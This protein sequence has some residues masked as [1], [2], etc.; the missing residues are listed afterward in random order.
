VKVFPPNPAVRTG[1]VVVAVA[2]VVAAAT[3]AVRAGSV[4]A[5]SISACVADPT[6]AVTIVSDPTGY[7]SG[8]ACKDAGFHALSWD[9]AGPQGPKGAQGPQ[10]P[11]G[12]AG[13]L[14]VS[15][16]ATVEKDLAL[17]QS[18]LKRLA[19]AIAAIPAQQAQQRKAF[20]RLR[21]RFTGAS[22]AAAQMNDLS[23]M[24]NQTSL[25]HQE[26]MDR[27]SKFL[28]ALSNLEKKLAD[29]ESTL[30]SSL[31]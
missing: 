21:S 13:H 16:A 8:A 31:K 30:E 24:S 6:G 22:T 25:A 4:S 1:A 29:T 20:L 11:A 26:A 5:T 18:R 17:T 10:G 28:S 2:A 14:S 15:A 19:T 7:N 23:E 12:P 3:G 27:Q 9:Q